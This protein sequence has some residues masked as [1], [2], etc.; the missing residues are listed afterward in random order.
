MGD[1]HAPYSRYG[2]ASEEAQGV[3]VSPEPLEPTPYPFLPSGHCPCSSMAASR[4][5]RSRGAARSQSVDTGRH[6][7][8]R[9][10]A[11]RGG[12]SQQHPEG[13]GQGRA[14]AV[15]ESIIKC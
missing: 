12:V 1:S 5:G 10:P 7:G 2:G 6:R 3:Q 8:S 13:A 11:T 15:G 9:C 14:L 4:A